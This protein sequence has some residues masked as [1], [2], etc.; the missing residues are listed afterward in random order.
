MEKTTKPTTKLTNNVLRPT[1]LVG[2]PWRKSTCQCHATLRVK[3]AQRTPF[4]G[5]SG[6]RGVTSGPL[7]TS[8][9][10]SCPLVI[11]YLEL[12]S[13]S[14]A[15]PC[16]YQIACHFT[17]FP[18]RHTA[19]RKTQLT[20]LDLGFVLKH[21]EQS[22]TNIRRNMMADRPV[23]FSLVSLAPPHPIPSPALEIQPDG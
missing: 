3:R 4:V 1:S 22:S 8:L 19:S 16:P 5:Q 13:H 23:G 18:S 21:N 6:R 2:I 20:R 17:P 7:L 9:V 14:S 15:P 12:R 11:A 10:L